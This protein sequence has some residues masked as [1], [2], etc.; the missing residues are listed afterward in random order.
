MTAGKGINPNVI[1][2]S[3]HLIDEGPTFTR[4]LGLDLGDTAGK[5]IAELLKI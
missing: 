1:I 2:P 4:L 5:V 3:I